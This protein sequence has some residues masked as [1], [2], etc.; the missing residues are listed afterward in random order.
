MADPKKDLVRRSSDG[1]LLLSGSSLSG[2]ACGYT[3]SAGVDNSGS[4][5]GFVS[6]GGSNTWYGTVT[7]TIQCHDVGDGRIMVHLVA[8]GSCADFKGWYLNGSKVSDK[9]DDWFYCKKCCSTGRYLA[10]FQENKTCQVIFSVL[11]KGY[12]DIY[13]NG[14]KATGDTYTIPLNQSATFFAWPKSDKSFVGWQ[15]NNSPRSGNTIT[16]N[17][18][19]CGTT[20]F[21][22]AMFEDGGSGGTWQPGYPDID[23]YKVG[24][25]CSGGTKKR[26]LI[27]CTSDGRIL[28]EHHYMK[29]CKNGQVV[30]SPAQGTA[31]YGSGYCN[32]PITIN[33]KKYIEGVYSSSDN[34]LAM[35][36]DVGLVQTYTKVNGQ[37]KW[38]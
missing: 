20:W 14:D 23:P 18:Y 33:G 22:T 2:G 12:G 34:C 38:V 10:R 28:I 26:I 5:T 35:V 15:L 8:G 11:P 7:P 31:S 37:W 3:S 17:C 9:A 24:A 25:T 4:G 30:R 6:Y 13:I 27:P 16:F 1:K 29:L 19:T 36:S 32:Y 21:L